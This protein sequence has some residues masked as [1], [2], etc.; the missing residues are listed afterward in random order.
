MP[1]GVVP[2]LF[3]RIVFAAELEIVRQII[4]LTRGLSARDAAMQ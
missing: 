3:F 1:N 4:T 2:V